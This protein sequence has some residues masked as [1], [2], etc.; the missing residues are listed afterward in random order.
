M[1]N[2]LIVESS[3]S[4]SPDPQL[5]MEQEPERGQHISDIPAGQQFMPV[6]DAAATRGA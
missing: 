5:R 1:R 6:S 2:T 4:R 3:A